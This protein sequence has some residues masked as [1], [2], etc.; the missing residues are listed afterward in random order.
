MLPSRFSEH[1]P[2][3]A[4]NPGNLT[5]NLS[6]INNLLLMLH[7]FCKGISQIC[8]GIGSKAAMTSLDSAV[9]STPCCGEFLLH[10]N[11]SSNLG[12]GTSF[13]SPC[14]TWASKCGPVATKMGRTYS[15]IINSEFIRWYKTEI[16]MQHAA[17]H[18]IVERGFSDNHI[19]HPPLFELPTSLTPS[20]TL[21]FS[22]LPMPL[23]MTFD[24]A[25][26]IHSY[27]TF[28]LSVARKIE[29]VRVDA[30]GT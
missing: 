17:R 10:G 16:A 1:L 8:S 15:S 3:K 4:K 27:H 9:V 5:S 30:S 26:T 23:P 25:S 29:T 11:P 28:L 18:P 22:P 6:P 14:S 21:L 13:L 7:S 19:I 24:H 20:L 2:G 12:L